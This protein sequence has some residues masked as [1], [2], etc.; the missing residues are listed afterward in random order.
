MN[1]VINT[2]TMYIANDTYTSN[3]AY[4]Y[5]ADNEGGECMRT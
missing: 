3:Y 4:A 1:T 5:T 2:T